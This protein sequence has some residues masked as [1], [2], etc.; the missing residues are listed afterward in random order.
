LTEVIPFSDSKRN[1]LAKEIA[2]Y[3]LDGKVVAIPTDTCYGLATDA[4][5]VEAVKRVFK[6]KKRP[7]DRPVSIFLYSVEEIRRYAYLEGIAEKIVELFPDKITVIFR[8]R[9]STLPERYIL[10]NMTVGV[11]I[12]EFDFPR[13]IVK[14]SGVPITA[15][16]ANIH[17]TPPIYDVTLLRGLAGVDY[18]VD[19]G[20]LPRV[21]VSTVIDVSGGRIKIIRV[22]ALTIDYI[23]RRIKEL[24]LDDDNL[25][26]TK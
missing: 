16:S 5:N 2:E 25:V 11:R 19:Y 13:L 17:G 12:P 26:V 6:I 20:G 10:W 15:T 7:P 1:A 24:S 23:R 8:A 22:G 3:I 14:Y 9:K 4:T 18:I 21:G